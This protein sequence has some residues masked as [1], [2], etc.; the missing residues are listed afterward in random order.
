MAVTWR[1]TRIT[2]TMAD[3]VTNSAVGGGASIREIVL[4]G[5]R[6]RALI[7]LMPYPAQIRPGTQT[8]RMSA[9]ITC[10]IYPKRIRSITSRGL[11][12]NCHPT[13]RRRTCRI[14]CATTLPRTPFR[15]PA[16]YSKARRRG[17]PPILNM[18]PT[19]SIGFISL[20]PKRIPAITTTAFSPDTSKT[21][22]R[23]TCWEM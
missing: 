12:A 20:A 3:L 6:S 19:A 1:C 14:S 7:G 18:R 22:R 17:I 10:S 23:S 15:G 5:Q 11:T 2:E 13:V 16:S 4:P 8:P 21:G 9:T